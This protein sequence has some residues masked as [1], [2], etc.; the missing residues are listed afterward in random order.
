MPSTLQ[1][2]VCPGKGALPFHAL[3]FV[4][5]LQPLGQAW[6]ETACC[7]SLCAKQQTITQHGTWAKQERQTGSEF[8]ARGKHLRGSGPSMGYL[9]GPK[10]LLPM[11]CVKFGN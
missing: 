4:R 9:L 7:V 10:L 2:T 5:G 6:R 11:G 3:P 8:L 1:D